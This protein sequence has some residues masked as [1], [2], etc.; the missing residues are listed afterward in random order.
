[1]HS[2]RKQRLMIVFSILLGSAAA[3]GLVLYA[4]NEGLNVFFTPTEIAEGKVKPGQNIRLGAIVKEG[5]LV[6]EGLEGDH[7]EFIATDT[8]E[9]VPVAY[10]GFLPDLFRE[11]QGVVAQ[12]VVDENGVFQAREILA[13]HDENYM[14]AEVKA[15]LDAGKKRQAEVSS[16]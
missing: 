12:G 11:G 1:M 15:A 9:E 16:Q 7:I 6:T 5:S 10:T 14:S 8:N 2:A 3:V 4:F 13:K